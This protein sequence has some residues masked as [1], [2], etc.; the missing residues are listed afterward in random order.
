MEKDD[1]R[2]VFVVVN[3][4]MDKSNLNINEYSPQCIGREVGTNRAKLVHYDDSVTFKNGSSDVCIG[5]DLD[6]FETEDGQFISVNDSGYLV[7]DNTPTCYRAESGLQGIGFRVKIFNGDGY[8]A[9]DSHGYLVIGETPLNFSDIEFH[10]DVGK[11]TLAELKLKAAE[12]EKNSGVDEPEKES[13]QEPVQKKD[14][15][16]NVEYSPGHT[17]AATLATNALD[18]LG[19]NP[20]PPVYSVNM[21][22]QRADM[23]INVE[24]LD[25]TEYFPE[26]VS[27][28]DKPP[29]EWTEAEVYFTKDPFSNG[30]SEFVGVEKGSN[31]AKLVPYGD[32]DIVEFEPSNPS[33]HNCEEEFTI[34]MFGESMTLN[35]RGMKTLS[36]KYLNVDGDG[37]IIFSD[38]YAC[39]GLELS[40]DDYGWAGITHG[41]K[42]ISKDSRGYLVI[43]D[44]PLL[45]SSIKYDPY[46]GM[47][48]TERIM[49]ELDYKKGVM[50]RMKNPEQDTVVTVIIDN[51][52]E[53]PSTGDSNGDSTGD[54]NG[55]ATGDATADNEPDSGFGAGG[56][57]GSGGLSPSTRDAILNEPLG[58]NSISNSANNVSTVINQGNNT[59]ADPAPDPEPAP[60]PEYPVP[61]P[62]D[63]KK[64][65]LIVGGIV[66]G[67]AAVATLVYFVHKHKLLNKMIKKK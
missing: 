14:P 55:D 48:S 3:T 18:P 23:S 1:Y 53:D 41:T 29:R 13:Q 19:E 40:E 31:R 22:S 2:A 50:E 66:L 52:T 16:K 58:S 54:S 20:T 37:N 65:A 6:A 12:A 27:M 32:M 63:T 4:D 35:T 57:G 30:F 51:G 5:R 42:Y 7:F 33:D 8:F 60:E 56:G 46:F 44:T 15:K 49:D 26:R 64:T 24:D 28:V 43:G 9:K 21:T 38:E 62:M 25:L 17:S 59:T 61:E 34:S 39:L 47:V 11:Q 45:M 67:V 10:K 36:G